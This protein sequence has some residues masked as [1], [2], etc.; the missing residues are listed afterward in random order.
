MLRQTF[1]IGLAC[2]AWGVGAAAQ[3][4]APISY[5]D[6][7]TRARALSPDLAAVR[8]R[9]S[10]VS[11]DVGIAGLLPNPTLIVGSTTQAARLSANVSLPLLV[12]GQ[13]GA[14]TNAARAELSTAKVETEL[15]WN[16][17][18]AATARAFVG[19][20]LAQGT[21]SA[22]AEAAGVVRKL[23]D[24]VN[25][26]IQVGAA[27]RVEGLRIHA[28]RLRADADADEAARRI[29]SS[30]S[31]L[32]RWIGAPMGEG[33]QISGEPA[34]PPN[35][36]PLSSLVAHIDAAPAVR[37]ENAD[38]RAAEAR[39][40]RE[41]ALV[42]PAMTLDVGLDAWDR[43]LPATTNYRAQLGVD[44][45]ILN[46]RGPYI[47]REIMAA[48][49]AGAR[50][51]AERARALSSLVVAYREL[52]TTTARTMTL[53]QGVLPASEAA[54]DAT[55]ESYALGHAPLVTVLDAERARI[56]VRLSLVAARAARALAW[57]DVE[58]AVGVP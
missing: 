28:E 36:P 39:A 46:Q 45:P 24:A 31:E 19:M 38:K 56:D 51:S 9:E 20:W 23:E 25:G 7:L 48:H 47:E 53:A 33:L 21:A 34:V 54:A 37:R 50:S 29:A 49:A 22:R 10:I 14:A 43:T 41:R 15:A 8:A 44:V 55:A 30:A 5:E 52:E 16:D 2:V 12:F 57:I 1:K 35:P 13:R 3:E 6:A 11:A 17:V 40:E 18:R 26:R 42:R 27:P 4:A 58:H 32:G